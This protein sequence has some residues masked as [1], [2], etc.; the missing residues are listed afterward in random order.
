MPRG[1]SRLGYWFI[2]QSPPLP[3]P[4]VPVEQF[5]NLG[6]EQGIEGWTVAATR[7][8]MGGLS[9]LAGFPTPP[10]PTPTFLTCPGDAVTVSQTPTFAYMLDT[11]DKPPFGEV[12]SMKL[13]MGS[14]TYGII[15]PPSSLLYGPAIYSNFYVNFNAGDTVSFDWKAA[16]GTDAYN[17]FAYMVEQGTGNYVN[18][19]RSYGSNNI[20][21]TTWSTRTVTVPTAGA[22]KF[23]FVS[24]GWDYTA[25]TWI[26]A[27]MWIDNIRRN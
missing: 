14:P 19:L 25:G 21:G 26:G 7:I 10:D 6:F 2:D 15:S 20:S 11:T 16:P 5:P 13:V 24:G 17:I 18:L 1:S 8:R 22:Y 27:S 3:D 12:Q 4:E 9:I 23:V